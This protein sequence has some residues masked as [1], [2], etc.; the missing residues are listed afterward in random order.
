[1]DKY[2]SYIFARYFLFGSLLVIFSFLIRSEEIEAKALTC[3]EAI[4]DYVFDRTVDQSVIISRCA[5]AHPGYQEH[6]VQ[7]LGSL[8]QYRN[9]LADLPESKLISCHIQ[10][11]NDW[12]QA[13]KEA[14]EVTSDILSRP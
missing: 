14:L 7:E 10:W 8:L 9:R 12:Q 2:H 1:M 13:H 11:M 6:R 5:L 3:I 4:G